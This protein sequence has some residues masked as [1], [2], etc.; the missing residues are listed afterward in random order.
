M[1]KFF[2]NIQ[3]A[4]KK[5]TK[6]IILYTGIG[7]VSYTHLMCIRDRAEDEIE[8]KIPEVCRYRIPE[9]EN[10]D[11]EGWRGREA[12]LKEGQWERKTEKERQRRKTE[13]SRKENER[14]EKRFWLEETEGCLLYTS[15]CWQ[16][17][18]ILFQKFSKSRK[19]GRRL[20]P[21][22]RER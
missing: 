2:E 15:I 3:P 10:Q 20:P 1:S 7:A 11:S 8:D 21:V 18:G 17:S 5:E 6:H 9:R 14:T 22:Y 4:V 16:L 19:P 13:C 12:G